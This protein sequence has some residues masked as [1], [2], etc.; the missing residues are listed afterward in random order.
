MPLKTPR[1][2]KYETD[3][4]RTASKYNTS[5]I[6]EQEDYRI[7][8]EFLKPY[9]QLELNEKE[10]EE[11]ITRILKIDNPNTAVNTV[12]YSFKECSFIPVNNIPQTEILYSLKGSLKSKITEENIRE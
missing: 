10:L 7:G 9:D 8:K 2:K 4:S 5:N 6:E 12:V 1:G 11:K 3:L